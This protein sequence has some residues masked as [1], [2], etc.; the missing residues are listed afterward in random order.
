MPSKTRTS[1][2]S[3][4]ESPWKLSSPTVNTLCMSGLGWL[5]G[6]SGASNAWSSLLSCTRLGSSIPGVGWPW[7]TTKGVVKPS[8]C[9]YTQRSMPLSHS[10]Y[11][12][13]LHTYRQTNKH[14]D[15]STY[16]QT[17]TNVHTCKLTV[18]C[19]HTC[20]THAWG[21]AASTLV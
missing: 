9:T 19:V 5:C 16:K 15:T 17:S 21:V 2:S 1:P 12:T 7:D 14:T 13:N 11:P 4:F 8:E 6:S 20:C 18:T 10:T 3:R